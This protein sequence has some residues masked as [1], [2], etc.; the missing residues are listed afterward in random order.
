MWGGNWLYNPNSPMIMHIS[1][2]VFG[3]SSLANELFFKCAGCVPPD[4]I[5]VPTH[6]HLSWNHFHFLRFSVLPWCFSK[7]ITVL[8]YSSICSAVQTYRNT[9]STMVFD[10]TFSSSYFFAYV[11]HYFCSF[12]D[13]SKT[14]GY[15][16]NAPIFITLHSRFPSKFNNSS[17]NLASSSATTFQ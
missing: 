2:H 14:I 6:L 4:S 17:F 1:P 10:A 8:K 7:S 16:F 11:S 12:T 9:S 15:E 13:I 3:I 5:S